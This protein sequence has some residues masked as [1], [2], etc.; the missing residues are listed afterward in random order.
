MPVPV[1]DPFCCVLGAMNLSK[2]DARQRLLL[3]V[4]HLGQAHA[5][6]S[7]AGLIGAASL[8][9]S[10]SHLASDSVQICEGGQG[11]DVQRP[12]APFF[13][14]SFLHVYDRAGG[15]GLFWFQPINIMR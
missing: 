11:E 10:A 15:L 2:V 14:S 13:I 5:T 8:L 6:R 3:C 4:L 9:V 12:R 7:F 1:Q